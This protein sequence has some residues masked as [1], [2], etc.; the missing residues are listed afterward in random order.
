MTRADDVRALA[1]KALADAERQGLPPLASGPAVG[2]IARIVHE[3]AR[4]DERAT[5]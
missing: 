4:G 2:E 3:S 1:D 5:A